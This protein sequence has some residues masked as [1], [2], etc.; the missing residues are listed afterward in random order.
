M[1]GQLAVPSPPAD[2]RTYLGLL[3]H[4]RQGDYVD[5]FPWPS[6]SLPA[7]KKHWIGDFDSAR[8][9]TILKE[10]AIGPVLQ[11][12]LLPCAATSTWVNQRVSPFQRLGCM[13]ENHLIQWATR[14]TFYLRE[15]LCRREEE[16]SAPRISLF[17]KRSCVSLSFLDVFLFWVW[18]CFCFCF[19][20]GLFLFRFLKT[21]GF[22]HFTCSLTTWK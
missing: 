20:W 10:V 18:C 21:S 5:L 17:W 6:W 4:Q 15:S 3:L 16:L 8:E 22:V 14:A 2:N 7:L 19:V 9:M 1:V 13:Q 12:E 11:E